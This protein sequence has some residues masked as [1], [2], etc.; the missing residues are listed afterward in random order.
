MNNPL[1]HG[2][3][4][5]PAMAGV[6]LKPQHFDLILATKPDVGWFEIHAENYMGNGGARHHYL[7]KIREHYP[8]SIHGVGLSLGSSEGVCVKH[9]DALKQLVDRYQP[10]LISEHLAWSRYHGTVLNDLLPVPYTEQSLQ[11]FS[12]NIDQ[13]Q[14]LLQRQILV[15][16]PSSYFEL[17]NSEFS[18]CEFLIT[19]AKR[20]GCKILLDVN[21]VYVSACNHG[22]DAKQYIAAIDPALVSEIHLA[23]HSVQSLAGLGQI[24]IDDHGSPICDEVWQLYQFALAHLGPKPT[25]IEWDTDVPAW[26]VLQSEVS[27]TQS[28][29]NQLQLNQ[30]RDK[31]VLNDNNNSNNHN[32]NLADFQQQLC[33]HLLSPVL[34][35]SSKQLLALFKP[36]FQPALN[37]EPQQELNKEP[38]QGSNEHANKSS[39]L[40]EARSRLDI[41][42]NNVIHSLSSAIADLYPIVKR[43]LGDGFFNG[44]AIEFV[45]LNP[46][47]NSVLVV[48]GDGFSEFIAQHQ[49]CQELPY[50]SDVARLELFSH[51]S[52][53]ALD[54]DYFDPEALGQVAPDRLGDL[55]FSMHPAVH[56]LKSAWPV[57][58]IWQ[59]NL[60]SQPQQ[61][62]ID[63]AGGCCLLIYRRE[64]EVQ[65]VNLNPHCF[66]F[67]K[68][69]SQ[70]KCIAQAWQATVL[71]AQQQTDETTESLGDHELGPMLGYLLG[72]PL[73]SG[74]KLSDS[75]INE[76]EQTNDK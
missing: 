65:V 61:I 15:E 38:S 24:R 51:Q 41:Y 69:L 18:E 75:E 6:G 57:E 29:I 4:S 8:L 50:L 49:A 74:F 45:R 64:F 68:Q 32:D 59:E 31:S 30:L 19:L 5:I 67:I 1:A 13:T 34:D 52:F 35:E 37:K 56:L 20:S 2:E 25:L 62:D 28:Y 66:N 73:F 72:L 48:Y 70:G 16:N 3:N 26:S 17:T 12:Q 43:L 22:F 27:K 58:A 21:N 44:L 36:F 76:K 54:F 55:I 11:V 9:L 39:T 33:K 47:D 63:L 46:P 71:Q 42:R 14:T 40:I 10:G 60:K 53:H 7:T 23:G